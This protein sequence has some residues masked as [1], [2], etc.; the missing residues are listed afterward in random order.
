MR[1]ASSV[2]AANKDTRSL[3]CPVGVAAFQRGSQR[4]AACPRRHRRLRP[5]ARRGSRN[6]AASL[7]GSVW[8]RAA[9]R[10]ASSK[11]ASVPRASSRCKGAG[12]G[13]GR[14][15]LLAIH[16]A[17]YRRRNANQAHYGLN[18]CDSA[19]T[20]QLRRSRAATSHTR[21]QL[22]RKPSMP[23]NVDYGN[24]T[25]EQRLPGGLSW[26]NWEWLVTC[27]DT[28]SAGEAVEQPGGD[29]RS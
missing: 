27:V 2:L 21:G 8:L 22:Q 7:I 12:T 6:N 17:F 16:H 9:V 4:P 29:K 18:S 24:Q 13:A 15:A 5:A 20:V 26:R 11:R 23:D 28:R 14:R 19:Q 3:P 25:G 10:C 1:S